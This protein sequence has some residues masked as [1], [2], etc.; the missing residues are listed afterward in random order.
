MENK[1]NTRSECLKDKLMFFIPFAF[2]FIVVKIL[3]QLITGN[4]LIIGILES[5][6]GILIA[7]LIVII[8]LCRRP[9]KDK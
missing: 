6:A 1:I 3:Y 5:I 7:A 8:F 9:K 4:F 2:A